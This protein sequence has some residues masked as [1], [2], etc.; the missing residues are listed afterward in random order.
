[1]IGCCGRRKGS[2]NATMQ[3]EEI[4]VMPGSSSKISLTVENK[5]R[6]RKKWMG[7]KVSS[8]RNFHLPDLKLIRSGLNQDSPT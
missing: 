6:R 2:I 3:I 5:T 8:V 4:G 1:M 7:K